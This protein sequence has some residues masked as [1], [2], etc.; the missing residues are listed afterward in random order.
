MENPPRPDNPPG[1]A[2]AERVLQEAHLLLVRGQLAAARAA[3][4]S[5]LARPRP[6]SPEALALLE[7]IR[8][9]QEA[10]EQ[11]PSS[12]GF[13]SELWDDAWRW[14]R[15]LLRGVGVLL[16]FFGVALNLPWQGGIVTA[17]HLLLGLLLVAAGGGLLFYLWRT[18]FFDDDDEREP[19]ESIAGGPFDGPPGF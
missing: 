10:A 16:V 18:R 4:E 2:T 19:W 15:H 12:G 7:Q 13:R 5:L 3:L 8:R 11:R 9:R 1:D 6:P 17:S 14:A